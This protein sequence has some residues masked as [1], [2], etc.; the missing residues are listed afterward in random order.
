[1]SPPAPIPEHD[2]DDFLRDHGC[3][4]KRKNKE[5]AVYD[6]VT[7]ELISGY[8]VDH[9]KGKREVKPIYKKNFLKALET[10]RRNNEA[11]STTENEQTEKQTDWRDKSW[12]KQQEQLD[13]EWRNSQEEKGTEP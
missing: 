12:Y 4:G 9:G 8:A 7:G 3:E 2:F 10:R 6:K 11:Q 13:D 1:M 5:Y